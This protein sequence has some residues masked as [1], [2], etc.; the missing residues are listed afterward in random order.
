MKQSAM[1]YFVLDGKSDQPR[2]RIEDGAT[3]HDGVWR[4]WCANEYIPPESFWQVC[5]EYWNNRTTD[6]EG[7]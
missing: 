5:A 4:S 6:L 2:L 3:G 7:D 1:I